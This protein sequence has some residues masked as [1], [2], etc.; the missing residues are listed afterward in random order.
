MVASKEAAFSVG[1][2]VVFDKRCGLRLKTIKAL[3]CLNDWNLVNT[4]QQ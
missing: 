3:V 2:R 4:R 1:G